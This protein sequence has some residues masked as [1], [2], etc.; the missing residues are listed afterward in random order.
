MLNCL[1]EKLFNC[2]IAFLKLKLIIGIN[3]FS[4]AVDFSQRKDNREIEWL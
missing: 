4:I 2:C 1:I 3:N